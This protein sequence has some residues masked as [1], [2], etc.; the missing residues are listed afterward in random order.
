MTGNS[1]IEVSI[2][3]DPQLHEQLLGILSQIGFEGFWEEG[4]TLRGYVAST[5]WSNNLRSEIQHLIQLVV[6]SSASTNPIVSIRTL[7][8]VN[9]NE[10]W[11]KTIQPIQITQRILIAPTW[12]ELPP[13][14]EDRILVR[15]DP[16]MSFGTGY[17]ETTR[18]MVRLLER[19]LRAGMRVLDIGTGTGILAITAAKLG[20]A[21]VIGVDIDE[22]AY[23]NAMENVERNGAT[24]KVCIYHGGL[25]VVPQT[26]YELIAAN[27]QRD[28]LSDLF[29]GMSEL[30]SPGGTMLLSGLVSED[31]TP[32]TA[33]LRSGGFQVHEE[34]QENEWIALAARFA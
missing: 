2:E 29:G 23:R 12:H 9:W 30:L 3:S 24:D 10:A 19:Y 1:Y 20:A 18:L 26:T 28:V 7:D 14:F 34:I 16:K 21:S 27:I 11:E 22:W 6:R 15:I 4:N 31:R 17:H 8:G 13:G 32:M 5:R 25:S 33:V